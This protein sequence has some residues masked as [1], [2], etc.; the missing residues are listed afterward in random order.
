[1]RRRLDERPAPRGAW[2]ALPLGWRAVAVAQFCVIG[3]LAWFSFAGNDDNAARYRTLGARDA[4]PVAGNLVVVFDAGAREADMRRALT[5][6][7]ARVVDGP[8]QSN[9]YVLAVPD[10]DQGR[11]LAVLRASPGVALVQSL[12][13]R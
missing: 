8:T 9:A 10:G 5:L 7:G 2:A 13:T 6:A 4:A 12:V 3:V 1:L 11:A